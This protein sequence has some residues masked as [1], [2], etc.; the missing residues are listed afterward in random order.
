M[1]IDKDT[2][3]GFSDDG[4]LNVY[5]GDLQSSEFIDS[6]LKLQK[7]SDRLEK[8]LD[9]LVELQEKGSGYMFDPD[10]SKQIEDLEWIRGRPYKK[11]IECNTDL[12]L[13]KCEHHP[14]M[15][16]KI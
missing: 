4:E 8:K 6:V 15:R 12:T 7:I 11:C 1:K 16:T 2:F 5:L 10:L 13:K 14:E 3:V 9:D